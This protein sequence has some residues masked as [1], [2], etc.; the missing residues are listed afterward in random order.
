MSVDTLHDQYKEYKPQWDKC[1]D[2][3]EGEEAIKKE[4][5]KYLPMIAGQDQQ[6]Y[7]GYLQRAFFFVNLRY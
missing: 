3:V 7:T 5:T 1:R 2:A 6:R 4:K